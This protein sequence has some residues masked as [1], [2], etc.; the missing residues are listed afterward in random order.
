[1][2]FFMGFLKAAFGIGAGVFLVP[3][4]VLFM[5]PRALVGAMAPLM[6][7]TDLVALRHQWRKWHPLHTRT[8]L[9]GGL[10]GLFLGIYFLARVPAFYARKAIGLVALTYALYQLLGKRW[11][12]SG[13]KDPAAS[14]PPGPD[15]LFSVLGDNEELQSGHGSLVDQKGRRLSPWAGRFIGFA[16]GAVSGF[17]HTG[18]VILAIYLSA[19]ALPKEAFVASIVFCLLLFD[20]VKM[21]MYWH[22][23][24]VTVPIL[25]FGLV[26]VPLMVLGGAAGKR[27]QGRLSQ[28][29]FLQV[30]AVLI[31]LSGVALLLT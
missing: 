12:P 21:A 24:V 1:M 13:G 27:L 5:P 26:L 4:G 25:G 23:G 3:I 10:L 22:L 20:L 31:L 8:L 14:G 18:G 9:E 28:E 11:R 15:L 16:A 17:S 19:L 29:R 2:S 6:L 7:I 30:T